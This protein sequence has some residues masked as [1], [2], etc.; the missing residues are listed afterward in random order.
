MNDSRKAEK[1]LERREIEIRK[2]KNDNSEI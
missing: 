1:L 2:M